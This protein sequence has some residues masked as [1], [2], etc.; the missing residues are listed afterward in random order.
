LKPF[1][2]NFGDPCINKF[3]GINCKTLCRKI[4]AGLSV[5]LTQRRVEICAVRVCLKLEAILGPDFGVVFF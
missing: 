3:L 4:R 2:L 1:A 5:P